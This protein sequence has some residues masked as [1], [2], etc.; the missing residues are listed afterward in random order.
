M[1]QTSCI[2]FYDSIIGLLQRLHLLS[3]YYLYSNQVLNTFICVIIVDEYTFQLLEW[4]SGQSGSAKEGCV[5]ID[6]FG[7]WTIGNCSEL[8]VPICEMP[9]TISST[10]GKMCKL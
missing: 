3:L 9:F 5:Y 8:H 10:P 2:W 4:A 1:Y 7:N 6:E